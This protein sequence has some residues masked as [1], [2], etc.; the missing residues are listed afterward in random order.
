MNFLATIS[1]L[2]MVVAGWELL[3]SSVKSVVSSIAVSAQPKKEIDPEDFIGVNLDG[4]VIYMRIKTRSE[5]LVGKI[6]GIEIS[7]YIRIQDDRLF[8]YEG[9]IATNEKGLVREDPTCQYLLMEPGL[10][11]REL[12]GYK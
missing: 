2:A 10:M 11:Y 9:L 8:E 5:E 3:K 7:R 4:S 1:N 6:D 12:K